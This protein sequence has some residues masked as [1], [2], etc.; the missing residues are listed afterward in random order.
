MTVTHMNCSL[1]EVSSF[2]TRLLREMGG[3]EFDPMRTM[4]VN[5][6]DYFEKSSYGGV[7]LDFFVSS[8]SVRNTG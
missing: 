5:A 6:V 4:L 2:T 7:N 3:G 1:D 8:Q